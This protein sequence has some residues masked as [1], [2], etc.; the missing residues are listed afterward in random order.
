MI[1][2]CDSD[3]DCVFS[4]FLIELSIHI[5]LIVFPAA[6]AEGGALGVVFLRNAFAGGAS[7][8]WIGLLQCSCSFASAEAGESLLKDHNGGNIIPEIFPRW[9]VQA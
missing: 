2:N 9:A 5:L 4:S 8:A 6:G 1:V 7:P 3:S